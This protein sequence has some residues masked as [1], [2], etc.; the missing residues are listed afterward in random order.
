MI[1][2]HHFPKQNAWKGKGVRSKRNENAGKKRYGGQLQN[3]HLG[4]GGFEGNVGKKMIIK[5]MNDKKTAR[6]LEK[7]LLMKR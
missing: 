6:K 7:H 4:D 1:L 2:D 5:F 3:G